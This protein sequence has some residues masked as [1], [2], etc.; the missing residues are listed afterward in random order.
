MEC[1][2]AG[3]RPDHH[4]HHHHKLYYVTGE[5]VQ[6]QFCKSNVLTPLDQYSVVLRC[7]PPKNNPKPSG[8]GHYEFFKVVANPNP[9]FVGHSGWILVDKHS[10]KRIH[11]ECHRHHH[12]K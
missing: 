11:T 12:G 3:N 5:H 1:F 10:L 4:H 6:I 9:K 2:A 7:H 8:K